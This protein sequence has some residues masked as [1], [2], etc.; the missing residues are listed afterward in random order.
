M[1]IICFTILIQL[2]I[3]LFAHYPSMINVKSKLA[4]DF[5]DTS[6]RSF[7]L[8]IIIIDSRSGSIIGGQQVFTYRLSAGVLMLE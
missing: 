7:K 3:D 5:L 6:N 2:L 4:R 8:Q 1:Y